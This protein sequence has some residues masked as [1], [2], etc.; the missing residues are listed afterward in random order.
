MASNDNLSA[1]QR[2]AISA[3]LV[4][5]NIRSAAESAGIAERTLHRWLELPDF[6][7]A[8]VEAQSGVL[9]VHVAALA[10]ELGNNR[11][12]IIDLRDNAKHEST[13]LRAAIAL[14]ESLRQWRSMA[15]FERRLLAL[16]AM[17]GQ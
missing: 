8:L 17:I 11:Q 16:E 4:D 5:G 14:D 7:A 2:N 12:A 1:K 15:E 10:A 6:Q 3:L 13:R 9:S